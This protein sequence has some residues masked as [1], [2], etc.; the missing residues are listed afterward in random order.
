MTRSDRDR[1]RSCQPAMVAL[2]QWACRQAP[3]ALF[4]GGPPLAHAIA[5]LAEE[6]IRNVVRLRP[7]AIRKELHPQVAAELA[8]DRVKA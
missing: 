6:A 5:R 3:E 7:T 2:V 8:R 1:R 4:V